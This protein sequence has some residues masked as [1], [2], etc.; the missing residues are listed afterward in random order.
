MDFTPLKKALKK[1][2][3]S[4]KFKHKVEAKEICHLWEGVVSDLF[5]PGISKKTKA[6]HFRSGKLTVEV[7]NSALSQELRLN[8]NK[9]IEKLNS[10]IGKERVKK[11]IL[12]VSG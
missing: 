4:Y 2:V 12:K 10:K 7:S 9:I 1:R 11:V 3:E 6:L 5:S 8:E